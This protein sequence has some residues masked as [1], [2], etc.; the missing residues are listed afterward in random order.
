M[1]RRAVLAMRS[2]G[3][4]TISHMND[5]AHS[6]SEALSSP[7]GATT[8]LGLCLVGYGS[9]AECHMQAFR[10]I[11]TVRPT[12]LVGRLAGPTADFADQWGFDRHTLDLDEALTDKSVDVVVIT[13]PNDLHAP[14]ADKALRAGKHVLLEIPIA[15]SLDDAR[16]LTRLSREVDRHLMVCHTK[17]FMPAL[18]EVQ[19]RVSE[20][21][22]HI[23]QMVG[24]FG[25]LR[26]TNTS[27]TGRKRS[28][29]DNILWHHA[30]HLVDLALWTTG[31][32]EAQDV[33]CRFGPEHPTQKVMDMS[34]SMA[35]PGGIV[36]TINLSY[37]FRGFLE[38]MLFIGQEETLLYDHGALIDGEGKQIMPAE[39][40]TGLGS[41][42]REFISAVVEGRD[43]AVTGEQVLPCM[44]VL[45][46][47]QEA[48]ER[49]CR[50]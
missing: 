16:R 37:N 50:T 33:Q 44:E 13:S 7:G 30:A 21:R 39:S 24:F 47:A 2:D 27:W 34:L 25:I 43:P 38:R 48:A 22:L 10:E 20:D 4:M 17:R 36:A 6:N 3:N 5:A 29:T 15:M 26:H 9:I 40:I 35:I 31:C 8:A 14:Q 32:S 18:R 19:R 12:V 23:L 45:H 46:K 42:N 28:W 1:A 41:Q 11:Q 49:A